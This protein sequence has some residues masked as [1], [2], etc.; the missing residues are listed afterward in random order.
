[1]ESSDLHRLIHE[2]ICK[3]M[4]GICVL[5]I[6][7]ERAEELGDTPADKLAWRQTRPP[8]PGLAAPALGAGSCLEF[9]TEG[10]RWSQA[11]SH[12]RVAGPDWPACT[13]PLHWRP[14][15]AG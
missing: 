9:S 1:M 5:E 13:W 3:H 4:T 11:E 7:A 6:H 15:H 12:S 8:A 10:A 14:A 2:R